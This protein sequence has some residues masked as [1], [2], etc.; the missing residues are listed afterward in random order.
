MALVLECQGRRGGPAEEVLGGAW[1]E[2]HDGG[3]DR[4]PWVL[5]R[6][7]EG[8]HSLVAEVHREER[9]LRILAV[10]VG[11]EVRLLRIVDMP[12]QLLVTESRFCVL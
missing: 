9:T 4:R 5:H 12:C 10:E 6:A 1:V 8:R 3:D 2:Q 7:L 11:R